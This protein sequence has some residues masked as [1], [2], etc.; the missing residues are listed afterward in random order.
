MPPGA[1][2]CA[3]QAGGG[4]ISFFIGSLE[5][6]A[7]GIPPGLAARKDGHELAAGKTAGPC[8]CEMGDGLPIARLV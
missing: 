2:A 3:T 8:G 5:R 1:D 4:L 7:E 6:Q